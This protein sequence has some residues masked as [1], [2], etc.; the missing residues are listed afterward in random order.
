[1]RNCNVCGCSARNVKETGSML[2]F[3]FRQGDAPNTSVN[4]VL[5]FG[6]S[7]VA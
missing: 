4:S 2:G 5:G 6:N 7:F 3:L 1:M